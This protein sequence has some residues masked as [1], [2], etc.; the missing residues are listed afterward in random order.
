MLGN[1]AIEPCIGASLRW[2]KPDNANDRIL[3]GFIELTLRVLK[4]AGVIM[5]WELR[6]SVRGHSQVARRVLPPKDRMKRRN[7]KGPRHPDV[8][9]NRLVIGRDRSEGSMA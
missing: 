9:R 5:R 3:A 1:I 7:S 6:C 2:L 4:A 8:G